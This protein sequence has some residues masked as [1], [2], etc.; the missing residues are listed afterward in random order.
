MHDAL[1]TESEEK[2]EQE[3]RNKLTPRSETTDNHEIQMTLDDV[4]TS[5]AIFDTSNAEN[6][7]VISTDVGSTN[8]TAAEAVKMGYSGDPCPECGQFKL[9]PNGSCF[10]CLGCGAT[11]GCS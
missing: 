11:T 8:E 5:D 2:N 6:A 3:S 9:V 10:K 7:N 1:R 4:G